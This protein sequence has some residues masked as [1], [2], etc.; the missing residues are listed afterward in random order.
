[1]CGV[2][3]RKRL[4]FSLGVHATA[5]QTEMF[6][7]S[8]CAKE[9]IGRAY[10]LE[11]IYIHLNSQVNL[12]ALEALRATLKLVWECQQALCALSRWNKVT[13]LWVSGHCG[14]QCNKYVDAFARDGLSSPLVGP[15]PAISVSPYVGR[16]KV[17]DRLKE[18]HS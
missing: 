9:C 17:K 2:R 10:T 3:P 13:L 6:V 16:L 5:F 7:I 8:A 4:S 14:I 11:H 18:K 1:M 15:K 12:R